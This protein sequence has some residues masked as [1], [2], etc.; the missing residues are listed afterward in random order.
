[1][2]DVLNYLGVCL[3]FFA[4]SHESARAEYASAALDEGWQIIQPKGV[5][6]DGSGADRRFYQFSVISGADDKLGLNI[7]TV[8][9]YCPLG[10]YPIL[11]TDPNK[12]RCVAGIQSTAE[13]CSAT[14]I[15]K[16][17]FEVCSSGTEAFPICCEGDLVPVCS[18]R[19]DP[20]A[21]RCRQPPE[22]CTPPSPVQW[23]V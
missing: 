21:M 19:N 17:D 10:Q 23:P 14:Q 8:D 20:N 6:K 9:V 11:E 2:R 1:M 18:S 22:S 4:I 13:T 5:K 16:G 15:S 3:C 7:Q 12:Q